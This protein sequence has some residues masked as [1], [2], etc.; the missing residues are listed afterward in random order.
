MTI[1][2]LASAGAILEAARGAMSKREAARRAGIAEARWRQIVR[3]TQ[4]ISGVDVPVSTRPDTLRR[5]AAAVG[6]DPAAVLVAAGFPVDDTDG[7]AAS[8]E[9]LS[10]ADVAARLAAIRDEV[11]ALL[12]V[13]ADSDRVTPY[14]QE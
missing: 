5:M 2:D 11:T 8:A 1:G 13:I 14:G 9:L 4:R 6:A 10:P 12:A 7:R 3:G